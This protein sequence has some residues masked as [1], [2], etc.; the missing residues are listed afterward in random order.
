VPPSP[1]TLSPGL[2]VAPP[3]Y[4]NEDLQST[5]A[6]FFS[7]PRCFSISATPEKV[8]EP[9]CTVNQ[10]TTAQRSPNPIAI[11]FAMAVS[12]LLSALASARWRRCTRPLN[13]AVM[14][15]RAGMVAPIC[16]LFHSMA[17]K[18]QGMRNVALP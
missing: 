11:I 3:W 12:L 15:W 4:P 9:C 16:T 14:V 10:I 6:M 1:Q 17:C 7:I 13:I 8:Y 5:P 18:R 2:S